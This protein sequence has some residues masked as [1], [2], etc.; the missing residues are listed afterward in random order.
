[1]LHSVP[2]PAGQ[3]I[4]PPAV[5]APDEPPPAETP[6]PQPAAPSLL[7]APGGLFPPPGTLIDPA[8][9]KTSNRIIFSWDPVGGANAY[10]LTIRR[11]LTVNLYLVREPRF[12]FTNL[13][14]LD[15]GR[16]TW[17]VEAVSLDS[18]GAVRRH[19]E[20]SAS[21]F[22]LEVPRPKAPEVDNPGIIYER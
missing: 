20:L 1:V 4:P 19:G 21:D 8:Y 11:G 10:I 22:T 17:Q 5:T 18:E 13:P 9:L 16:W 6:P 14:S 7:Q 3:V 2:A 12:V 15:N